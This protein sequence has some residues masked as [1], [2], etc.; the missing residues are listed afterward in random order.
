VIPLRETALGLATLVIPAV[1]FLLGLQS[2]SG[3]AGYPVLFDL[4][5]YPW[6]LWVLGVTGTVAT[7]CG[8]LDWHYHVTGRRPVGKRERHGELVALTFGGV[9]LFL[10]MAAASVSPSPRSYLLPV[11]V[12]AL[13]TTA[14]ICYDEFVFH[15][16]A[17]RRYETLLHRGLV[18]GNGAAFLAW[19][20][21]CFVRD[22]VGV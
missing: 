13:F 21:W 18:L 5:T 15:R 17:C 11:V 14:V 1:G 9:P 2:L 12:V 22:A 4:G 20:H 3:R 8:F 6:E 19:M 16:K 10:L 7:V